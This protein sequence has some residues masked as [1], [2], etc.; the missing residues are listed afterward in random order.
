MKKCIKENRIKNVDELKEYLTER[1][2]NHNWHKY[3]AKRKYISTIL[4]NHTVYL[5]DG[6]NWNDTLDVENF[7]NA[8]SERVNF[9]LCLSF[10]KSESVAMWMLY[11]GNEGGMI[12]YSQ[13]II[14]DILATEEI[15][16]PNC[17]C[18]TAFAVTGQDH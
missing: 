9:G 16:L 8:K 1:A 12:D 17:S 18:I 6:R 11:S 10:S 4:E 7:N 5:S 13:K 2:K 3:Y 14:N 15:E